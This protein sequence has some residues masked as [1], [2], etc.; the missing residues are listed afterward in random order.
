MKKINAQWQMTLP[1]H[2]AEE[3]LASATKLFPKLPQQRIHRD[4]NPGNILFLDGQFSG[5]I[6]FDLSIKSPRLFNLCY[7]GT[8][9]LF[10]ATQE[11]Q[12][13]EWPAFFASLVDGYQQISPLIHEEKEALFPMLCIVQI[14]AVA[15]FSQKSDWQS[16]AKVNRDNLEFLYLTK[17]QLNFN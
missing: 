7:M 2:F 11:N 17:V 10:Q 6:D 13:Q 15:Y 9:I 5:F 4:P 14:I 3:L 12:Y 8:A 16:L 1:S